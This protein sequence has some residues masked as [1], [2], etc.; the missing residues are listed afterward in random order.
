MED[1]G[2]IPE[3]DEVKPTTIAQVSQNAC[4]K[5]ALVKEL[6][7]SGGTIHAYL[8]SRGD[9]DVHLHQFNTHCFP[10]EGVIFF[11]G[12]DKDKWIPGDDIGMLERH[13]E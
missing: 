10:E 4:A 13:Y 7:E 12:D 2:D 3:R 5:V 1:K 6:L 8:V 11:H 9:D